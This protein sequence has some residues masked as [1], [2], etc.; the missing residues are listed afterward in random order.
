MTENIKETLKGMSA[1]DRKALLEELRAEERQ[2]TRDRR[3]AY[4]SIR[5]QFMHE[6]KG[7]LLPLVENVREFRDWIEREAEGFYAIMREY[8]QLRKEDQSSF[9]IVDGDMKIEV[10]SNKVKTF[11]E[12]ADMAAER[13]MEYLKAY[14]AGSEKGYD[15]PM[16]QLAMTLLERNRQGDLDYKNISK[17]YEMEDRFDEEY[18]SIMS[19]FRESHT[20]TKTA[21]N[22][23]FSQRDKNGVWRRIEP[24]FCRL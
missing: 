8:G 22:F 19:L 2:A 13:L 9:T 5:A 20:V 23:Y 16:Y 12:R 14:V 21:T 10:R 3:E 18:K 24:S 7:H 1:A 17:L 4:E 6:V 15:D 11:D